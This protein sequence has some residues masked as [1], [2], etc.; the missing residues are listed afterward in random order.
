LT[1]Q[2]VFRYIARMDGS[3][4]VASALTPAQGSNTTSPFVVLGSAT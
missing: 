4:N 1:D 3:A 2:E